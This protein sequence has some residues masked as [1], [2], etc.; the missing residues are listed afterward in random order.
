MARIKNRKP[1]GKFSQWLFY[2]LI[3]YNYTQQDVADILHVT[4]QSISNHVRGCRLPS[5]PTVIAYCYIFGDNPD[6]IWKL[7]EEES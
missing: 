3:D 4:K 6:E 2:K 7:V 1:E 5:Y